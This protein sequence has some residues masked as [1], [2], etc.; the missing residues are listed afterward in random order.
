MIPAA[1][2]RASTISTASNRRPSLAPES[3]KDSSTRL[4]S[5]R[6]GAA[7]RPARIHRVPAE[8]RPDQPRCLAAD[9]RRRPGYRR[10]QG[11]ARRGS[12]SKSSVCSRWFHPSVL[13]RLRQEDLGS[14]NAEKSG[15]RHR[16]TRYWGSVARLAPGVDID[17]ACAE[18][19]IISE[20]LSR[21]YPNV[22]GAMTATVVPF[23]DH[24]AAPFA[25]RCVCSWEQSCWCSCSDA[26]TS[27]ACC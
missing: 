16:R 22:L 13:G 24:L 25:I 1:S 9:V 5:N 15:V 12:R 4:A 26:R 11:H 14:R 2:P 18:L 17:S 23:R 7:V 3:R 6:A 8:R 19:S 21:E 27:P 10:P 20:Q